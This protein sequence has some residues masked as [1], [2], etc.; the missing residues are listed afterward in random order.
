MEDLNTKMLIFVISVGKKKVDM[1]KED[2][3]TAITVAVAKEN[4]LMPICVAIVGMP[5][6]PTMMGGN[7]EST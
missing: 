4:T 1:M 6:L 2:L 5:N 3:V 7:H